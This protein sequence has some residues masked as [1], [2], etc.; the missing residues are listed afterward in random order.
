MWFRGRC[1]NL[2]LGVIFLI[3]LCLVGAGWALAEEPCGTTRV[4]EALAS[5]TFASNILS[6][7]SSLRALADSMLHEA[8]E[9]TLT[10]ESVPESCREKCNG[11]GVKH[12][13][14]LKSVPRKFRDS[15]RCESYQ[16]ED[17]KRF[18]TRAFDAVSQIH[19][20]I[21]RFTQGFGEFGNDLYEY[22]KGECSPQ[23]RFLI[24]EKKNLYFLQTE[25]KCG[26]PRDKRDNK[27]H[28]ESSI[29]WY[30]S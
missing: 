6:R 19:S 18:P 9:K 16:D 29:E 23:Y 12:S 28:L 22:C 25:A 20:W 27:Y 15:R 5:A 7:K 1:K 26:P 11:S 3:A 21:I 4:R 13:I 17:P 14:L 10:E 8:T 24:T 2:F 30:C